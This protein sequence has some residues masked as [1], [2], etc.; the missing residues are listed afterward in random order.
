MPPRV[1]N[2]MGRKARPSFAEPSECF[3][4]FSSAR[5]WKRA[6]GLATPNGTRV[7]FMGHDTVTSMERTVLSRLMNRSRK[8]TTM[9]TCFPSVVLEARRRTRSTEAQVLRLMASAM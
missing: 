4:I 1:V 7:G 9:S 6:S 2:T 8:E 3:L 5:W